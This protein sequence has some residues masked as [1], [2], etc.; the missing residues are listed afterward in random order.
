MI[1][2]G[3]TMRHTKLI[4]ILTAV[5]LCACVIGCA[6]AAE[7]NLS[8]LWNSGCDLLFH[9]D[10]VT[11]TGEATFYLDGARFKT[12][13]LYYEQ[14]GYRSFYDLTLSTPRWFGE[15]ETGWTIIADEDG[16]V[17]AM[18][19]FEP[20]IY[21]EG[22]DSACNTLLRRSVELDAITDLCGLLLP[23]AESLLP[24]NAVTV[25]Q[26]SGNTAVHIALS[27]NELPPLAQSALNLGFSY[28]ADRWFGYGHDQSI[29]ADDQIPSENYNTVTEALTGGTVRWSLASAEADF[30]MDGQGRL[31]GGSGTLVVASTFWDGTVRD[32]TVTFS[33][34]TSDWG[35][36]KVATFDP[37]DYG[38]TQDYWYYGDETG[39]DEYDYYE[40][41]LDDDTLDQ[42]T[43]R[44]M[45]IL[46]NQGFTVSPAA[47]I[48]G[49]WFFDYIDIEIENPDGVLYYF[50]FTEDGGLLTMGSINTTW[51]NVEETDVEGVDDETA[52]AAIAHALSF[53]AEYQ[54]ELAEVTKNLSVEGMMTTEDGG[55]YLTMYDMDSEAYFVVQ[56]APEL[57]VEYFTGSSNG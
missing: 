7:S 37:E 56:A 18:E 23:Q 30:D 19:A 3:I 21:H 27:A 14:E 28:L 55:L 49:W 48:G 10:N 34:S 9:T 4:V 1:T 15:Q 2:G 6:L 17:Y 43:A 46:D 38:V 5:L 26:E 41:P 47:S 25:S 50:S 44:A 52:N 16:Y 40:T 20:G 33:F 11:V 36:T 53:L 45:G 29:N 31:M 8:A 32:V 35:T 13:Q 24:E 12:A 54:P 39:W 57:R 42:M 22:F 51:L